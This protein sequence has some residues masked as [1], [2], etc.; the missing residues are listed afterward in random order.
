MTTL[1]YK[2][3]TQKLNKFNWETLILRCKAKIASREDVNII[4]DKILKEP[5][6]N[7]LL[8]TLDLMAS[9]R[10]RNPRP[11]FPKGGVSVGSDR[12]NQNVYLS[13]GERI[14]SKSFK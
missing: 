10:N 2:Q 4:L 7:L 5:E 11:K 8:K 12:S 1:D 14:I 3:A 6:K 13:K 9:I